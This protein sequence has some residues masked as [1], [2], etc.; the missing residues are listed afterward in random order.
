[1]TDE[2][3]MELILNF[4]RA[5]AKADPALFRDVV[6]DDFEWHMHYDDNETGRSTGRVLK[7][8]EGM[9]EEIQWRQNNWQN[10]EFSEFIERPAGDRILQMFTISGI[11]ENGDKFHTDAVD[12]YPVSSGKITRKDTYWKQFR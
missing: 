7:G 12:V 10:V 4:R 3:M 8:I 5:Y 6:S 2:E 11:D 9:L 1:M